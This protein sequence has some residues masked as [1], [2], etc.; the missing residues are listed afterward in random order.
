[1]N[2]V[3]VGYTERTYLPG[4]ESALVHLFNDENAA[5]AGFVPRTV[6]YW[7]WCCLKRPDVSE[8]GILIV[9]I[10]NK[11][12]GYAVVGKS[13]NVWELCYNSSR[14]AKTTVSKLL[15]WAENYAKSVGSDSVVLNAYVK[16]TLVREVSQDMDF[17]ESPPDL[18]FLS[19]LDLPQLICEVLQ[20][21]NQD[22][23][24]N[25]VFWFD[26]KNCPPWC[27]PSFG[28]KLEKA[29]VTILK[30]PVSGSRTT[31]EAE[32][33]TI[34]ALMF[35]SESFLKDVVSSK[36]HFYPVW[37]MSKVQKLFSLLK[38]KTPWLIPRADLG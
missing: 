6:E 27:V 18:M 22:L 30:E 17:A 38:I 23:N 33:S 4:D 21:R 20:A 1:L 16:D 7:R 11:V 34:V 13:G 19:V 12:V 15:T 9:E 2:D 8:K 26:L 3:T 25:E 31:I 28:V 24:T 37:K 10:E 36:V 29:Q 32:M 35:E 5:L 14:N